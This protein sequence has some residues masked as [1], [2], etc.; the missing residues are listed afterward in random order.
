MATDTVPPDT[1]LARR[2]FTSTTVH[3]VDTL[4]PKHP[5]HHQQAAMCG[6]RPIWPGVWLE[7][8]LEFAGSMCGTCDAA[9]E[10]MQRVNT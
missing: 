9:L 1:V 5:D 3:F 10:A 6:M 4:A 2:L 7:L 8:D